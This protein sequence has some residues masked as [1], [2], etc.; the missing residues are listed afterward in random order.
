MPKE[1]TTPDLEELGRRLLEAANRRDFDA[2]M[3]FFAPDAVWR[4]AGGYTFEGRAAIR[5]FFEELASSFDDLHFEFEEFLDLGNGV[6][7]SVTIL[8]GR[9]VGSSGE[10]RVRYASVGVWTD[11]VIE[12]SNEYTKNFDKARAA[13]ETRAEE[14]E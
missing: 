13:A 6:A 4:P 12:R 8:T 3:R 11:G 5:G 1:S 9:P 14:R 2:G 10:L 7:F